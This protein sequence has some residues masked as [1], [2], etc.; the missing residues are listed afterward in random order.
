[1]VAHDTDQ[2]TY[3]A[4]KAGVLV[5]LEIHQQLNT[6]KL[7][8]RC[9]GTKPPGDVEKF[10]RRLRP[11][12]SEL[13]GYDPAALFERTKDKTILYHA[14]TAN[15]CM[16]ERDEEPPHEIDS[17]AL[18]TVLIISSALKS[19]IFDEI[20]T[21]RKTV[22]DGSNTGGFQRTML[23]S[24]G[25]VLNAANHTVKV[26]SICLEE[27]SARVISD[28]DNIKEYGLD[29]LGIPLVEIALEPVSG[30]P[31]DVRVIAQSLGRLLR[32]TGMVARGIGTI[33][34]DVNVSVVGGGGIVE[35]KGVQQLEQ[36]E[37]II[38][39]EGMRQAGMVKVSE[40]LRGLD[41][42]PVSDQDIFDLTQ[43]M[44]GCSSEI[45]QK[46]LNAGHIIHA[47]ALRK[48]RGILGYEPY[49]GIRLGMELGQLVKFYDIGGVFHSDELPRYGIS[50]G[51]IQNISDVL[52]LKPDDAFVMVAGPSDRLR[53]AIDSII[54]RIKAAFAGVP[55]ETRLATPD[56][57]T[58][59]LRPRPGA[60][61]MYPETDIPPTVISYDDLKQAA[62]DVPVP[63]EKTVNDMATRHGLATHLAEQVLDSE[64]RHTFADVIAKHSLPAA[65]VASSLC[66][67]ITQL[68]R[69]GLQ[70]SNLDEDMIHEIFGM[71]ACGDISKEAVEIIFRNIMSGDAKTVSES[72]QRLN[73][74]DDDEVSEIL[75]D[76]V[77]K[78]H[79]TVI[80]LQKRAMG[81]LMGMAMKRLRGRASGQVINRM[82]ASKI[83]D[84]IE[85][86]TC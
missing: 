83:D 64:Y 58:I 60:A 61:R 30:T 26:Q 63:W 28:H 40:R 54:S 57:R 34:Q 49:P 27:D 65:F 6:G 67:T 82:L 75:D 72:A 7:F 13:G 10:V 74:A 44:S 68:S 46:A 25:G 19:R 81:P 33:R 12:T 84:V 41:A 11:V 16:V 51:N 47:I 9:Q 45:I 5:G 37:R 56:G 52:K 39:Y 1:M 80:K 78:N 23:V 85:Q 77:S 31:H 71:L 4:A 17:D 43:T 48:M 8:C 53:Y 2:G 29:R 86:G 55:S 35:I 73:S 18:K 32:S 15:S 22:I 24:V 3:D 14:D 38:D 36:L 66:S 70:K 20:Y 76:I 42:P 69:E 59:F 21:M 62:A 79:H 50:F